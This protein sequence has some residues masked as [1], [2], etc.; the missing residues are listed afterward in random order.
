VRCRLQRNP[1]HTCPVE[2]TTGKGQAE[3]KLGGTVSPVD[4]R[5]TFG[6]DLACRAESRKR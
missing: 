4:V 3:M 6:R 1:E 5:I 2:Q